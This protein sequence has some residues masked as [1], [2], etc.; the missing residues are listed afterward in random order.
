MTEF[1]E[2]APGS[3]C[4]IDLAANDRAVAK[5]FYGELF[6]WT[7]EDVPAG[8]DMT[9]SIA[10]LGG[11]DVGALGDLMPEQKLQGIPSHWMSYVAV[12]DADQAIAK[13]KSL[14]GK[15]LAEAFDV[16]DVGRM[17][18]FMDPDGAMLSVWQGRKNKGVG[19]RDEP[20]TLCWNELA[21]RKTDVAGAFYTNLFG[22]KTQ[23]IT[24]ANN[25]AYTM[26]Q[27]GETGIGGMFEIKPEM[28]PM[29]SHWL[30]YLM[31]ENVDASFAKAGT[32]GAKP[33]MP[34]TDIPN[35]GRFA[36]LHDPQGAGIAIYQPP[37]R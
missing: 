11:L 20:G 25:M 35:M 18:I 30:P 17:G 10:K 12:T 9:Y 23:P 2:H 16:M 26:F 15:I 36:I 14:G 6:G 37:A 33:I 22:W 1:K 4:W 28:G 34:P 19:R 27:N 31:V 8:P 21:T 29:P 24:G 5:K 3:F 13:A 7:F 32:L